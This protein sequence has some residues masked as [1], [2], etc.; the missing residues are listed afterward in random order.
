MKHAVSGEQGRFRPR[1][2][3]RGPTDIARSA[4]KEPQMTQAVTRGNRHSPVELA[5]AAVSF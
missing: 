1:R 4:A 5:G 2:E 3:G